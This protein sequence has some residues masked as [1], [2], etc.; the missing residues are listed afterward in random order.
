LTLLARI[1]Q[2][3]AFK[4]NPVT[5]DD[6]W[7]VMPLPD[8]DETMV[9]LP[10]TPWTN[11]PPGVVTV[12]VPPRGGRGQVSP[13]EVVDAVPLVVMVE[14]MPVAR[15]LNSCADVIW[16]LVWTENAANIAAQMVR[17]KK[18]SLPLFMCV[19]LQFTN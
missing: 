19:L 9:P 13:A 16:A 5:L 2:P 11:G 15:P 1:V 7:L 4:I 18:V 17:E 3:P 12:D 10:R 6:D 14:K 8:V